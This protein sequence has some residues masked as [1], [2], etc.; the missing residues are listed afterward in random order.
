MSNLDS[1]LLRTFLAV[2][3]TGSITDGGARI[4]RSQS[5]ISLQI[6]RLEQTVGQSVFHRNGR[7]VILTD[8]GKQL[9]PVAKD[10]TARLD[11]TLRDLTATPLRGTLRLGIPDDH[12]RAKL[13]QIVGNFARSHP[14][15]QLDV[16][17]SLSPDFPDMLSKGRLDLAVY[18]VQNPA[19]GE[20]VVYEDPTH[21]VMSK[22]RNLL[23]MEPLP[24]ALFDRACWWREAAIASLTSAVK[25]YRVVYSS[26]SVAGVKAAVEAGV[27]VGVLGKSSI[28]HSMTVLGEKQGFVPTPSSKLVIGAGQ[29]QDTGLINSMA[30]EIRAAFQ[31]GAPAFA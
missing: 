31:G 17:C 28:D 30:S 3:E 24:V 23:D 27:A 5:A 22:H 16:T 25:A 11:A 19:P 8:A 18:E 10:V 26:Q 14:Q 6:A 13:T 15:V 1:D 7:G 29:G 12:G 9:Y 21:W 4:G 20:E 2:A